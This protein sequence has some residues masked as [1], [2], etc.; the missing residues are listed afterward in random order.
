MTEDK[1]QKKNRKLFK[2]SFGCPPET[3]QKTAIITPVFSAKKFAEYCKTLTSFR[4][5]LCSG[6]TASKNERKF[7]I[8]CCN[9]G[10]HFAGDAVLLFKET[11]VKQII[12]AGSC[13]GLAGCNIGD[14]LVGENAFNGEGFTRYHMQSSDIKE[15][16]NKG[17][18]IPA[19]SDYTKSLQTFL[20][21]HIKNKKSLKSGN[22]FTIGSI[23]AE[24]RENLHLIE[25]KRF[26]AV[27]MELSAVYHA[28]GVIGRKITALMFVSDLPLEKPLWQKMSSQE[29]NNY[30]KTI[31]EVVRFS[32]EF[33]VI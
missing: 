10:A 22:I 4:G 12:F 29:K 7:S 17:E 21:D 18:L 24:D 13:G 32:V 3:L 26:K 15:I 14:L 33:A 9:M 20:E 1:S 27:D 2:Y 28:A 23:L 31:E 30:N 6:M 5:R 25:K 11:Q 19:D 8:I 16:F